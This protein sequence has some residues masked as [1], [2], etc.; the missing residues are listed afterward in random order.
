[1]C[2]VVSL[3]PSTT[4]NKQK[5]AACLDSANAVTVCLP[6]SMTRALS[7][8]WRGVKKALNKLSHSN[9]T[10]AGDLEIRMQS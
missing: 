4:K 5:P 9:A 2:R 8:Q 7:I 3:S 6:P 10:G 1:M